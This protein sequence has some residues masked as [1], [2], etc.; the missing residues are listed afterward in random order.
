ML[1]LDADSEPVMGGDVP[2]KAKRASFVVGLADGRRQA[3]EAT[4]LGA[5][6]ETSETARTTV[7]VQ[8]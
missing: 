6:E 8:G 7:P 3:E 5:G 4:V 2:G 1:G